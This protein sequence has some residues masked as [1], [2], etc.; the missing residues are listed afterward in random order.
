M[1]GCG[2]TTPSRAASAIYPVE[3]YSPAIERSDLGK[4]VAFLNPYLSHLVDASKSQD[5]PR[6]R[7]EVLRKSR[8]DLL[9][10]TVSAARLPPAPAHPDPCGDPA[11]SDDNPP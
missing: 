11:M 3:L 4:L 10:R 2:E 1:T 7:H 6:V 9:H 8:C 5:V